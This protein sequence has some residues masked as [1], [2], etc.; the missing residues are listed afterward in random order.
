MGKIQV[1]DCTLRD[2]GYLND[3]QFGKETIYGV[4]RE[5][6]KTGVNIFELCFMRDQPF[7]EDRCVFPTAESMV[8]VF[9]KVPG[10]QYAAM[11][12]T[13]CLLPI[14]MLCDRREDSV[15]LIRFIMWK[16]KMDLA[17]DYCRKLKEKGYDFCVQPTR[18]DQY[19]LDEFRDMILRFNELKPYGL[20]IV[21]TF[22]LFSKKRLLE[23]VEVADRYLDPEIALGYHAHNN[24]Q[25]AVGNAEAF[26]E[27]GLDR[28]IIVD[29]SVM[30]IGRGAGNLPLEILG[31]YLNENKGAAFDIPHILEIADTYIRPIFKEHPWGYSLPYYLTAT[32]G[33]NPNYADLSLEHG[34][35][36]EE[37]RS[38]FAS[39][40]E[41]EKIR[42]NKENI[43][44]YLQNREAK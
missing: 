6:P 17:Y 35:S 23:Y 22:G 13:G 5:V 7:S 19:S 14:E 33:C 29:A 26:I 30:G 15:D 32:M 1:M 41:M 10:V 16:N 11:I 42:F 8:K 18:T 38:F 39:M 2:G 20:Y 25:Q 31:R 37:M 36:V 9:Q 44:T 4:T 21:D 43:L 3:W 34:L 12:E 27:L 40:P 28:D 24:L